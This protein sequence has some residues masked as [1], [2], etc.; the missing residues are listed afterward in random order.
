MLIGTVFLHIRRHSRAHGNPEP[1]PKWR[2][3]R[4]RHSRARGNPV[5]K[6]VGLL[7]LLSHAR[8]EDANNALNDLSEGF[9]CQASDLFPHEIVIGSKQFTRANIAY[10]M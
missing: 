10:L 2:S 1:L 9:C 5:L 7:Y 3:R 6:D 4:I 8:T